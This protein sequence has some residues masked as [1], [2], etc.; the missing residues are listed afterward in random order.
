MK[1]ACS[2]RRCLANFNFVGFCNGRVV[3]RRLQKLRRRRLGSTGML[4][5]HAVVVVERV[6]IQ[7]FVA[8]VRH[9]A[10]VEKL[11]VLLGHGCLDVV[12]E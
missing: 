3:C 12:W 5:M 2:G 8:G 9:E 4:S 1:V 7:V 6:S 10:S 11:V